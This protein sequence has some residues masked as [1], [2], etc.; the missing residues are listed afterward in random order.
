M[1]AKNK[2]SDLKNIANPGAALGQAIGDSMELALSRCL[3]AVAEKRGCHY[4]GT[5]PVLTPGSP[6]RLMELP[7]EFG[8]KYRLDAV[9]T[10]D[11]FRPLVLL[12]SKYI[13]YVK[14][15]RDKGSWICQTH[16]ALRSNFHSVRKSI[17]VLAGSWSD[18]SVAMIRSAAVDAFI[19]PYSKIKHLLEAHGVDYDWTEGDRNTP[20]HALMTYT[21]LSDAKKRK[22]GEDMLTD[23]K[24]SLIKSV[25]SALRFDV[26]PEIADVMVEFHATTGEYRQRRFDSVEDAA[27]YLNEANA[28][29]LFNIEDA[30]I[31]PNIKKH[32]NGSH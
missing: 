20:I 19:I 23:I 31:M 15:N 28:T 27:I 21:K 29:D 30:P 22:V 11:S 5:G 9:I 16:K 26:T 8:T 13:R 17:A 24:P 4:L 18:P 2:K 1:A 14:H 6:K 25:D 10:D 32:W 3:T 7:D 12:E